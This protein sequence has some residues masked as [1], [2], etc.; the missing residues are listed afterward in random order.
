MNLTDVYIRS[1]KH[2]LMFYATGGVFLK[3]KDRMNKMINTKNRIFA[4]SIEVPAMVVK[5][6]R[7]AIKAITKKVSPQLSMVFLS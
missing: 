5:P 2:W 1:Y 3:K 4:I 6:K 7:A